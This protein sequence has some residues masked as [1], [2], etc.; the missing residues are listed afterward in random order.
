MRYLRP[1]FAAAACLAAACSDDPTAGNPFGPRSE[2]L[3]EALNADLADLGVMSRNLYVGADVDA[4]IA[5]LISPDPADDQATLVEAIATLQ[6]TDFPARAAAIADEIARTRPHVV[7]LQEV[8]T[9][10]I[11]LPPLGVSLHLEFLPTLLAEL[12]ARGLQ[13]DV[14]ERVRN[15]EAVP[16]PGVSL[17]DEDALLVDRGRVTVHGTV[18]RSFSANIGVVVPGVTLARGWVAADVTVQGRPYTIANTH[19]ESGELPQLDQLRAAQALELVQALAG[20]RPTVIMGDLND[21]PGSPMYQVLTGAGYT[22]LWAAM[23][24]SAPGY[25]CCHLPDLSNRV[26]DFHERIDYILLRGG[27][28]GAEPKGTI[29]LVGEVPADRFAGLAHQLWP[30][31]HAGLAA[32]LFTPPPNP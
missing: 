1:L 13:Y 30:S 26:A 12:A 14:A 29:E 28:D 17:V 3:P 18:A 22:D 27:L 24:G 8:S 19:L 6:V 23:R 7:G 21:V 16:F 20:P 10:D 25:T 9:I 5:A 11:E 31:D 4:V 15:I 32:Q 2:T